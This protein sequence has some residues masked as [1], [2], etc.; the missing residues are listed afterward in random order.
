VAADYSSCTIETAAS[1]TVVAAVTAYRA[2]VFTAF[3]T[4][5]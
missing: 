4:T 5:S 3:A 1:T 2:P